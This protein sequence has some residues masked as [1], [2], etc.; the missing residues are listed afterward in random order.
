ML[1]Y[2]AVSAVEGGTEWND[3]DEITHGSFQTRNIEFASLTEF[4]RLV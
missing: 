2:V 3:D 1:Q 4:S